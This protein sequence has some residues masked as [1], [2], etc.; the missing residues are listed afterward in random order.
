[1]TAPDTATRNPAALYLA[2][3]EHVRQVPPRRVFRHRVYMWLVDLDHLPRLPWWLRPFAHFEG[4]DHLGDPAKS[5]RDNLDAWLGR[6]HIDLE[7]GQVL[8]LAN[9]RVL[10]H[11]FNPISVFWCHRPDGSLACVVAEV[12]NTYGERHCYL[13]DTDE[14]DYAVTAKEFYVSPF[15][16]MGGDYRMRLPEPGERLALT[17]RLTQHGQTPLIATL[18]GVRRPASTPEIV[19]AVANRPLITRLVSALIRR[20]GIAL[21]L[22]KVPIVKRPPHVPQEGVQ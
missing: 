5:I 16:Q 18:R 19:R 7:G 6:H 22:R 15:Q 10:G 9:A 11:V 13:L 21:W 4:R 14:H 3:V 20:H 17:I 1:M 2:E 12:H 8:M